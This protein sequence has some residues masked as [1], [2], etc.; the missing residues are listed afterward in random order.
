MCAFLKWDSW[1][2][3]SEDFDLLPRPRQ[4]RHDRR[5]LHERPVQ[6]GPMP[7]P[8]TSVTRTRDRR[9][10]TASAID[11]Y[12]AVDDAAL[13][14]LRRR[15]VEPAVRGTPRAASS[16]RPRLRRRSPSGPT[17]GRRAR[18]SRSAHR[19][20]RSTAGQSRTWLRRTAS[21]PS[22]YGNA[23]AAC[24]QSGFLGTSASSP[25]V[26]GAAA[27]LLG[28]RPALTVG[29]LEARARADVVRLGSRPLRPRQRGRLGPAPALDVPTPRRARSSSRRPGR[30]CS[31]W[32]TTAVR[33]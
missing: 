15:R 21:R 20:R 2:V 32:T 18:R 3:T 28:R 13:R 4:R 8:R 31:R 23:G 19:A 25:Q 30:D 29:G 22:T 5:G 9:R 7:R 14:P 17:A 24:G 12:S 10:T 26:A 1:P 16:S 33:S 6:A 27:I 11:R